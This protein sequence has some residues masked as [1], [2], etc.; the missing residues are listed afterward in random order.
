[1]KDIE[2]GPRKLVV[3]SGDGA[4]DLEV[5]DHAFDSVALAVEMIVPVDGH[6]AVG[7]GRD[8]GL[9]AVRLEI[10]AD[11]VAVVALVDDQA[12][13]PR[14][15]ERFEDVE[16]RRVVRFAAGEVER[17]RQA[18]GIAETM[19]FTS[20]PT[21]RAVKSLFASTPLFAPAAETW[22]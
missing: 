12:D 5:F 4:V 13:G 8:D 10:V 17:E 19:N 14:L 15:G 21:P 3:L 11:N 22:S 6:F 9:D 1:M 18:L 20:E 16:R 7:A 2:E